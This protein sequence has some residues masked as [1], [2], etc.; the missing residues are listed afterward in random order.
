[1]I[2]CGSGLRA[3]TGRTR[4]QRNEVSAYAPVHTIAARRAHD[5]DFGDAGLNAGTFDAE[6][7]GMQLPHTVARASMV[8]FQ[9]ANS[10][11]VSS[12][13]A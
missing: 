10:F 4:L 3:K 13:R 2:G 7:G 11:C 5:R 12:S 9:A 8:N 6:L 1:M